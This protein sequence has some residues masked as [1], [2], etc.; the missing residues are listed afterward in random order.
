MC[1]RVLHWLAYILDG[2]RKHNG[3]E[4]KMKLSENGMLRE[5]SKSRRTL[6]VCPAAKLAV[7]STATRDAYK[8]HIAAGEKIAGDP[9]LKFDW[10]P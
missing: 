8:T 5:L 6:A 2:L 9:K 3:L 7:Q 10:Y 4:N 1:Q